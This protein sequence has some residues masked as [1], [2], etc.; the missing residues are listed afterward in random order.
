MNWGYFSS[1]NQLLHSNKASTFMETNFNALPDPHSTSYR[2]RAIQAGLIIAVIS[3][4]IGLITYLSGY[5]EVLM[6]SSGL[7]WVNNLL[8]LGYTGYF[9]YTACLQHRNEDLGG[10]ISLGRCMGIGTVS[11]LATGLVLGVWTVLFMNVIAPEFMD[12]IIKVTM[13]QMAEKG[14]GEDEIERQMTFVR[15][16]FSPVSFFLTSLIF[17]VFMGF[18]ISLVIGLVV[19]KDRPFA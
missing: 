2:T 16:F 8:S 17:S 14:L 13:D 12:Q 18:I 10:Y 15:P 5:S 4:F 3:I 9:I 6:K 1:E 11:G 19:K 7:R